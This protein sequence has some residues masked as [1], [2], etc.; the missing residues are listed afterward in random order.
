VFEPPDLSSSLPEPPEE[1][2]ELEEIQYLY[3]LEQIYS[4]K[5][6]SLQIFGQIKTI[7]PSEYFLN[8]GN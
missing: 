7:C 6:N 8:Q 5:L 2:K 4:K 1:G 3:H